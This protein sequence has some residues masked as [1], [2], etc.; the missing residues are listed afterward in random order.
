[1]TVH[2]AIIITVLLVKKTKLL[3]ITIEKLFK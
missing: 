3:E 2:K 1:M